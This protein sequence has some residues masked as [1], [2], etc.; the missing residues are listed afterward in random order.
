MSCPMSAPR[1]WKRSSP[2]W[3]ETAWW[4]GGGGQ[5]YEVYQTVI[6]NGQIG[7]DIVEKLRYYHIADLL[8]ITERFQILGGEISHEQTR[9]L[10]I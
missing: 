8:L 10:R 7:L 6:T 9:W 2:Q 4:Q 3:S 5:G 1:P